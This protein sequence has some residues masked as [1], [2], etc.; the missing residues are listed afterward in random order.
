MLEHISKKLDADAGKSVRLDG[1]APAWSS[2]LLLKEEWLAYF[3][4]ESEG[5]NPDGQ[6]SCDRCY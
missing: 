4:S 3:K 2:Q 5:N 1:E 6:Y